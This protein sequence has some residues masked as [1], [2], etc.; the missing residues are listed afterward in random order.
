MGSMKRIMNEKKQIEAEE[1][2][3]LGDGGAIDNGKPKKTDGLLAFEVNKGRK[4]RRRDG[5]TKMK[6]WP[7]CLP[8]RV[9]HSTTPSYMSSH[10]PPSCGQR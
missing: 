1:R 4:A 7:A 6:V 5:S 10:T 2:E 9:T 8:P 3:K